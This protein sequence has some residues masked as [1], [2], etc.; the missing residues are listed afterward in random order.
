MRLVELY[1]NL[2]V[3]YKDVNIYDNSNLNREC[4][5]IEEIGFK[6][7]ENKET[8]RLWPETDEKGLRL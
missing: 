3:R 5:E 1:I 6:C 2:Y 4:Y 7:N 8:G